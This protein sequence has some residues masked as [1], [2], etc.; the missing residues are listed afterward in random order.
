MAAGGYPGPYTKGH[1]IRGLAEAGQ[2]PGVKVFHAGTKLGAQGVET[3]GG[4][5]LGVTASGSDLASAVRDTYAAVEKIHFAGMH[6]RKDIARK[7]FE[8]WPQAAR[9]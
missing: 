3:S 9:H 5:V 6:Y 8:R 1:V 4:R 2:I 7:G